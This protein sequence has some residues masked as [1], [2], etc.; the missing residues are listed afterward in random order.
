MEAKE[1][2]TGTIAVSKPG[3]ALATARCHNQITKDPHTV[4]EGVTKKNAMIGQLEQANLRAALKEDG[5][6]VV[7]AEASAPPGHK[8]IQQYLPLRKPGVLLW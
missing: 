7:L 4:G 8:L 1:C 2:Q 3:T 6:S 5:P